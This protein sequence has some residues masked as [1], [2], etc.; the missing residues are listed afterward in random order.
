[1]STTRATTLWDHL[2]PQ[3][4]ALVDGASL[5]AERPAIVSLVRRMVA[6]WSERPLA[7]QPWWSGVTD[8][9]TPAELSLAIGAG[10][11]EARVLVEAQGGPAS[12]RAYWR[13]GQSLVRWLRDHQGVDVSA[14]RL[15]VPLFAPRVG[16]ATVYWALWQAVV[17]RGDHRTFKVYLNPQAG[18][19]PPEEVC[20]QALERLGLRDSWRSV[21]GALRPGDELLFAGLDLLPAAERRFKLYVRP[22]SGRPADDL[23]R[24]CALAPGHPPGQARAFFQAMLG[25]SPIG[26]PPVVAWHF[27]GEGGP[28]VR[29]VPQLP[30]DDLPGDD[31][32]TRETICAL[33]AGAGVEDRRYRQVI[34]GLLA[35]A[36]TPR[37]LHSWI[38]RQERGGRARVTIYF[39]PCAYRGRH[40]PLARSPRQIW[41]SPLEAPRSLVERASP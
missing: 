35:A 24:L 25:H 15:L 9:C 8:D 3:L 11:P 38:S 22:R 34:D 4:E 2:S 32:S 21:A 19:A 17:F 1:M 37:R 6:S 16:G 29:A 39:N 27:A 12:P 26:R 30:L 20:R 36:S 13:A 18:T 41:P 31:R 28:P 10:E 7:D 14:F 40:G 5:Q 23:E 33:L